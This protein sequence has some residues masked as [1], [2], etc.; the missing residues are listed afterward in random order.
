MTPDDTPLQRFAT[1]EVARRVAVV[2]QD[3][4]DELPFT[5]AEMVLLGRSPHC[6]ARQAYSAEDDAAD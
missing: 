2:S 3:T 5:V 6:S 4:P 1:R